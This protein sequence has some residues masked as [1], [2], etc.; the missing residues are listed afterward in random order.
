MDWTLPGTTI[1]GGTLDINGQN[2]GA[3]A[4]TVQGSGVG[5]NGAIVNNAGAQNNALRSVTLSGDAT[6]GG[7][8][9]WDV[10][11]DNPASM[12]A[13]FNGAGFKLTKVGGSEVYLVNVGNTGL[14]NIDVNVG[15]F[16]LQGNT[17]LGDSTK[18]VTVASSAAFNLYAMAAGNVLAKNL[19]LKGGSTCFVGG[20]NNAAM[21][22]NTT[23]EGNATFTTDNN[24]TLTGNL[25]GTGASSGL[26][27]SSTAILTLAGTQ[28]YSGATTI[29]AGTLQLSGAGTI[30]NV[31]NSATFELLS[32]NHTAGNISGAGTTLIDAGAALTATSVVQNT[33]TLG[34]GATLTIAP[35]PGGPL[36]GSAR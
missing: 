2:I 24:L 32:G 4:V 25:T 33:L 23:L 13:V 6:F 31:T 16:G 7:S 8:G 17:T 9:R 15:G 34:A 26:T 19:D 27:K 35:I 12:V 18:T 29:N 30:G 10:R 11:T 28:N 22:G 5:G 36:A 1:N 20:G 14:G 3:E 21:T